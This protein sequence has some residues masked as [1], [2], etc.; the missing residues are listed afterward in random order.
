MV[1]GE[2]VNE[3][4][5][6]IPRHGLIF[7]GLVPTAAR[8]SPQGWHGSTERFSSMALP[9]NRWATKCFLGALAQPLRLN[10][11]FAVARRRRLEALGHRAQIFYRSRTVPRLLAWTATM[12]S[13][14][15]ACVLP[16][17]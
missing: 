14:P 5:L 15:F 11:L 6:M 3:A 4:R 8:M 16:A 12:P 17:S 1:A 9:I 2:V 13:E 10:H 7:S